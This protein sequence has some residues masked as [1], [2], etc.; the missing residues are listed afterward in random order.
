[1]SSVKNLNRYRLQKVRKRMPL[2]AYLQ[3]DEYLAELDRVIH[4]ALNLLLA[5]PLV[6][7]EIKE[8]E[9]RKTLSLYRQVTERLDDCQ[10]PYPF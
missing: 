2:A 4:K 7:N 8:L 1:M 9:L 5:D 6:D 10:L 3:E